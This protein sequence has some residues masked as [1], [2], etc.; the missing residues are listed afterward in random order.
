MYNNGTTVAITNVVISSRTAGT[1]LWPVHLCG[2]IQYISLSTIIHHTVKW[3][4]CIVGSTALWPD[5]A[6]ITIYYH[7][8]KLICINQN[9]GSLTKLYKMSYITQYNGFYTCMAFLQVIT[10]RQSKRSLRNHHRF[11]QFLRGYG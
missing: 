11:P 5:T 10:N 9:S 1:V 4:Y 7:T 3:P 8:P 2:R 6:H